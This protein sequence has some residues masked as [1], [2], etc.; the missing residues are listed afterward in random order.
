MPYLKELEL[1]NENLKLLYTFTVKNNYDWKK[2][3]QITFLLNKIQPPTQDKMTD[4]EYF[5]KL[6]IIKE[7]YFP[8]HKTYLLIENDIIITYINVLFTEDIATVSCTTLK[9]YQHKPY[10]RL[11]LS[12]VEEIILKNNHIKEIVVNDTFKND[13]GLDYIYDAEEKVFKK[14]NP[15]YKKNSLIRDKFSKP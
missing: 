9:D 14:S 7:Q 13:V 12:L 2:R 5:K 10:N 11:A 3:S 6:E 4:Y 15:N 1:T 8:P